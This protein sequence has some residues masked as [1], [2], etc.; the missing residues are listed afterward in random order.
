M[1][2]IVEIWTD[3]ACSKNP[4]PGGWAAVSNFNNGPM[5]I[6]TGTEKNSTNQRMEISA[7][8]NG[9]KKSYAHFKEKGIDSINV[10]SDSAYV[11]NC[12]NDKWYNNWRKNGWKNSKKQPVINQ[13]L[14]EALLENKEYIESNDIKIN[15]IKVKG[16]T[17]D[18]MNNL[19]DRLAVYAR[20]NIAND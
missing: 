10:Y 12:M 4:G 19:C 8:F 15:F 9:L 17:D 7:V 3:G 1:S 2:N 6:L 11:C 20:E 18:E 16:H 13:E 14:W 5:Y